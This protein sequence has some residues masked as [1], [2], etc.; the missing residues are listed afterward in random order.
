M[1]GTSRVVFAA[2]GMAVLM[3]GCATAQQPETTPTAAASPACSAEVITAVAEASWAGNPAQENVVL[4]VTCAGDWAL[5][6]IDFVNTEPTDVAANGG[7]AAVT[8]GTLLFHFDGQQ[9]GPNA[10]NDV[11]GTADMSTDPPAYPADAQV[12]EEIWRAACWAG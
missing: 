11:C 1:A 3:G 7:V 9:W 8:E 2:I 6:T 12:P 5:A 10:G 4:G